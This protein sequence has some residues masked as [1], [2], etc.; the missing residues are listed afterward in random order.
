M[1]SPTLVI[2]SEV[3]PIG[4][5]E[6]AKLTMRPHAAGVELKAWGGTPTYHQEVVLAPAGMRR[7]AIELLDLARQRD[8]KD[9]IEELGRV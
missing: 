7:L 1:S 2:A 4:P 5:V 3:Q 6:V 8:G 9:W